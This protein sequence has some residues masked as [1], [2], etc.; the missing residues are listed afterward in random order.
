MIELGRLT[1]TSTPHIDAVYALVKLLGHTMAAEKLCV[2]AMT[3]D[4][5]ERAV[6]AVNTA[7]PAIA[8][9]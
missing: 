6:Q 9:D 2:R 7:G 5:V 4:V 8:A 1:D 3:R